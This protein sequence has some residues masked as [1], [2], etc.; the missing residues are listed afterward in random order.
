V[1]ND[2]K[3]KKWCYA[4]HI[5]KLKVIKKPFICSR[6]KGQVSW[7]RDVCEKEEF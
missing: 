5:T 1:S 2:E 3:L 7:I 6:K 4:W